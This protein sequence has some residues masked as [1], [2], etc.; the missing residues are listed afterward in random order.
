MDYNK[1]L[2]KNAYS[3]EPSGIRK[4]FDVVAKS[5]DAISLGVGEP[6]FDTPWESREAAV[7]SIRKGYTH[8][9]SNKGM[10]E[11]RAAITR[12]YRER[13]GLDYSANEEAIVTVGA[14][15]A[16]DIALRALVNAGEEVLIPSP[17]YVSYAPCVTLT[18]G[19]PVSLN[20]L[21]EDAFRV[22]A[23][24]IGK[25]VTPKTKAL[26]LPYPNN[27]SGAILEEKDL[28]E[29]AKV[30]VEKD[31]IVISDEIY[32]EL[33]YTKAGH[34]SIAAMPGMRERC[35]VING[36]SKAFAMTGWRL[37]YALAPE[38]FI[39]QM[40]KIHQYTIMCAPT[41]SQFAALESLTQGFQNGFAAVEEMKKQYDYRRKYLLNALRTSGL[42]CFEAEGA[43][44]LFPSVKELGMTGA[45]FADAL[46][47]AEKVAVVPGSAFGESGKYN[48]SISYAYSIK[49][50]TAAME[51]IER[52][53]QTVRKNG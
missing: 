20:C 36:F 14:S 18:G 48:V 29:I 53:L 15:E 17:S 35:I 40:Y 16:I 27:P 23:E 7:R 21:Q 11:L 19:I 9:T 22:R 41:A 30:C 37:G 43:F 38:P 51:K 49:N 39:Y 50:L 44:Y 13:Y 42:S 52:F 46:F 34:R 33:T 6:D 3:L 2:N 4:F 45:E 25:A 8:Y 31:L 28:E 12:Y 26:I 10:P 5:P 32:S 1:Y 24:T 47:A